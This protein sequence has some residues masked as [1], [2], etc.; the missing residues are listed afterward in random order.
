MYFW[1]DGEQSIYAT[2]RTDSEKF[3]RGK[4]TNQSSPGKRLTSQKVTTFKEIDSVSGFRGSALATANIADDM[5]VSVSVTPHS[6]GISASHTTRS[7]DA[8]KTSFG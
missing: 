3:T 2:L 7:E 1:P 4:K 5:D 8:P 6:M